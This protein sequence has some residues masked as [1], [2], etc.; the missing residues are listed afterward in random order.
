MEDPHSLTLDLWSDPVCPWCWIAKRRLE[1][2][3]AI[4]GLAG[5]CRW[6]F[7]AYELGPRQGRPTPVLEH[8]AAKY[9]VS[10]E[11]ARAMTARVAGLGAELGL[12]MDMERCL[13]APTYDAHRLL[14][15]A[16]TLDRAPGLAEGLHQAHFSR[17][18][19][20][21]DHAVLR[22]VAA[23]ACL[24]AAGADQVLGGGAYGAEVDKDEERAAGY[25]IS[26]VPFTVAQGRFAVPGAQSVAVFEKMLRDALAAEPA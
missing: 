8:L 7:H 22:Q 3:L 23:A 26:G 1:R 24:D 19:D 5:R 14:Q 17:G 6:H 12:V 4:T 11:E 2:A 20:L 9:S 15:W 18:L 16:Q 10:L 25:D 13:S 21:S